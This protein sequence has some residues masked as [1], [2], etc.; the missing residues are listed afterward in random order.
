MYIWF[1]L[2][3]PRATRKLLFGWNPL[4]AY[5]YIFGSILDNNR[6]SRR[7]K[8]SYIR[9]VFKAW[10]LDWLPGKSAEP[11]GHRPGSDMAAAKSPHREMNETP[12]SVSATLP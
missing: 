1:L 4:T 10:N 6:A 3:A 11:N 12:V 2:F 8:R 9:D 5:K 7:R